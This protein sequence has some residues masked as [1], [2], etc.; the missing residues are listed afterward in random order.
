MSGAKIR[1]YLNEVGKE[2]ELPFENDVNDD[3]IDE[4]SIGLSNFMT[5]V[6]FDNIRIYPQTDIIK[7]KEDAMGEAPPTEPLEGEDTKV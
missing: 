7:P 1:V 3:E 6:A 2:P 5:I 4:G